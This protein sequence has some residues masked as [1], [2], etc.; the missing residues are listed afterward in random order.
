MCIVSVFF[1]IERKELVENEKLKK[2]LID[3]VFKDKKRIEG[4]E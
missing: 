2:L 4:I 3:K 1:Y